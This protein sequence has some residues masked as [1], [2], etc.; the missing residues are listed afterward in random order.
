MRSHWTNAVA[1]ATSAYVR[2]CRVEFGE[3][4]RGGSY[5]TNC[6]RTSGGAWAALQRSR[7]IARA[8]NQKVLFRHEK[9]D[10]DHRRAWELAGAKKK[11]QIEMMT[12]GIQGQYWPS[13]AERLKGFDA[14]LSSSAQNQNNNRQ[15][16]EY[17][18]YACSF[19]SDK[20]NFIIYTSHM[21][22][23]VNCKFASDQSECL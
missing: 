18:N 15:S 3:I 22:S 8:Y 11:L 21:H 5:R 2:I 10:V 9:A 19:T 17:A 14:T 16:I 23:R 6:R 12:A 13:N 20:Q 4:I 1:T 7:Y